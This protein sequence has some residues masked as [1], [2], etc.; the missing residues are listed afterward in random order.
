MVLARFFVPLLF[1]G[2]ALFLAG[3]VFNLVLAIKKFKEEN[4]DI[5]IKMLKINQILEEQNTENDEEK[6]KVNSQVLEKLEY[7][8]NRYKF[9]LLIN[10]FI[11]LSVSFLAI[12]YFIRAFIAIL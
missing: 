3:G 2:I 7:D 5:K 1:F 12:V 11:Y 9:M 4:L 10:I 8:A 6:A